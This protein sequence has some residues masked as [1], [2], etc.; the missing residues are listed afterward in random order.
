MG[1]F[2]YRYFLGF[3]YLHALLCTYGTVVG[4]FIMDDFVDENKLWEQ[5]FVNTITGEHFHADFWI[6]LNY[7]T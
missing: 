3:L 4:Y 6:V 7:L 1:L 5:T 2:N